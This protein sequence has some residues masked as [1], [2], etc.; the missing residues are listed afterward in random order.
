VKL[1][2][3]ISDASPSPEFMARRMDSVMTNSIF[4]KSAYLSIQGTSPV[5]KNGWR[6]E[7][8][9]PQTGKSPGRKSLRA[10]PSKELFNQV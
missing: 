3:A 5:L 10:L 6:K 7:S 2:F 1:V 9:V 8:T 4:G